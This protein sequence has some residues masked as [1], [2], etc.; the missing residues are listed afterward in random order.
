MLD[1]FIT[2]NYFTM[3][4]LTSHGI[5]HCFVVSGPIKKLFSIDWVNIYL[6][7]ISFSIDFAW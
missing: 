3:S 5:M 4:K 6:F 1:H 2:L 7:S